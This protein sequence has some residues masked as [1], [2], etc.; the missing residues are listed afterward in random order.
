V[1]VEPA[2][3]GRTRFESL[4]LDAAEVVSQAALVNRLMGLADQDLIMDVRIGGVATDR[5]EIDTDAVGRELSAGFLK[6]RVQDRSVAAL[7]DEPL[8]PPETI[9][10][11]F[12]RDLNAM[13]DAAELAGDPA[14]AA[15][16]REAL[17]LGRLLLDDPRQVDLI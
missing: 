2:T 4:E 6:L 8:P 10:G 15:E 3:V 13:I 16:A 17:Q 14:A 5:L 9:A 12:L 7:P 1:T 11:S